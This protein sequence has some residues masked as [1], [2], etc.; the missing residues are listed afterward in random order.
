VES[1]TDPSTASTGLVGVAPSKRLTSLDALRGIAALWV[2]LHHCWASSAAA[3]ALGPMLRLTPLRLLWGARPPVIFFFVLSGFVLTLPFLRARKPPYVSF[4]VQRACRIYLPFAASIAVSLAAAMLLG[5]GP[6]PG[7]TALFND[8][9][10]AV[11]PRLVAAHLLMT[12]VIGET[13]LNSP[14]WSLVQEMRVAVIFPLLVALAVAAGWKR[15]GLAAAGVFGAAW[16]SLH[17]LGQDAFG[18]YAAVSPAASVL[19]TAYFLLPFVIGITLAIH[20]EALVAAFRGAGPRRKPMLWA[21]SAAALLVPPLSAGVE[22]FYS[23]GAGLLI[24]LVLATPA[25]ATALGAPPLQ[26]LGRVSYSLYLIHIPVLA[27]A[28]HLLRAHLPLE[29]I[30]AAVP[31]LSLLAAQ[32]MFRLVEAPSIRLG[33]RLAERAGAWRVSAFAVLRSR[34]HGETPLDPGRAVAAALSGDE[35]R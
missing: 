13:N 33:R 24:V 22:L 31:L 10:S 20:R 4:I 17:Y 6:T 29:W 34:R 2:V 21:A 8:I 5:A 35:L 3:I 14:M 7:A 23:L 25:A 16:L 19:L 27:A 15:I 1:P 18:Y 30:I 26:W 11:S 28:V 32:A 12:G 9:W